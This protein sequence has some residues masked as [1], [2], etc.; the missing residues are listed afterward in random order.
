[1]RAV[2]LHMGVSLDGW[3]PRA[4]GEDSDWGP[5]PEHEARRWP[6]ASPSSTEVVAEPM[7]SIPKVVLSRALPSAD[8]PSQPRAKWSA[9]GE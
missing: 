5:P 9:S 6:P 4:P 3:V 1:M 8:W 7:N 2:V